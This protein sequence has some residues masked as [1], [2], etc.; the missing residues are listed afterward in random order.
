MEVEEQLAYAANL[1]VWTLIALFSAALGLLFL[2][3][4]ILIAFPERYR[5]LAAGG[6]SA[7]LIGLAI[8]AIFVVRARLKA[9]PRFLVASIGELGRDAAASGADE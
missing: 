4:T 5:L 9:R 8:A 1:L 2:V 7:L 3:I 6:V